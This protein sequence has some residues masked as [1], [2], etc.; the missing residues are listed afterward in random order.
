[1]TIRN[2]V[3]EDL[4][5]ILRLLSGLRLPVAGVAE[6]LAHFLV[7]EC[8]GHLVGTVGLEVHGDQGLLRSL[9]VV[10]D[11]QGWGYGQHLYEAILERARSLGLREVVL[12]TETARKF[13]ARQGFAVIPREAAGPRLGASVEFRSACPASAVCMRLKL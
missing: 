11:R 8:D 6:H 4:P 2:A 9:G 1:M 7:L 13:F 5:G 10:A 12:L 3:P